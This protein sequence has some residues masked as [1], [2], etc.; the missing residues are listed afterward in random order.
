MKQRLQI[1]LGKYTYKLNI[2]VKFYEI[3]SQA[4]VAAVDRYTRMTAKNFNMLNVWATVGKLG[5]D[6]HL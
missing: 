5:S 6:K 3:L 4:P 2:Q 1:C